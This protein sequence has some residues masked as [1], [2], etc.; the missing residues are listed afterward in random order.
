M[1]AVVAHGVPWA[2]TAQGLG[3]GSSAALCS[4]RRGSTDVGSSAHS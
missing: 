2:V 4:G 1:A 3:A